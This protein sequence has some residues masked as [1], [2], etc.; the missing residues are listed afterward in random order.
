MY[1]NSLKKQKNNYDHSLKI[2]NPSVKNNYGIKT[3]PSNNL[4]K[5]YGI[6]TPQKSTFSTG[7][8][9]KN[10]KSNYLNMLLKK[11]GS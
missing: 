6:E 10:F 5:S 3:N 4:S 9:Q 7:T 8:G 11:T 2:Q 1:D